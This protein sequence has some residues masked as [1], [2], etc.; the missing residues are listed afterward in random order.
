M[1]VAIAI[2]TFFAGSFWARNANH[3]RDESSRDPGT[4]AS[5]R[6]T[7]G[8]SGFASPERPGR[9]TRSN[10]DPE[11][12]GGTRLPAAFLGTAPD[13]TARRVLSTEALEDREEIDQL[14][15]DAIR[16][17]NPIIRRQAFD[18]ILRSLTPE[19]ALM[20]RESMAENGAGGDQWRLF[21]Y[22]WGAVDA[23]GALAHAPDVPE[24]WRDGFIGSVLTGMASKDP[25][26]AMA[27]IDTLEAGE[28][29]DRMA[30]Q[31]VQGLAD[32]DIGVATDY[33]LG[34]ASQGNERAGRYLED[35]TREVLRSDGL[36]AGRSWAESLP[37]GSLQAGAL[38]RVANRFVDE[39]PQAAAGWATAYAGRD[40]Y[41]RV[42]EEVGDEW[43]E[44]DPAAAV[45][46]LDSLPAG[47]G[48]NEGM[49]SALQEWGRRDPVA[50][51]EY[52]QNM[53]PSAAK[54]AA[55]ISFS[56]TVA[57]EDPQTAIAWAQSVSSQEGRLQ[58][59]T[60][61]GQSWARRDPA[62]AAEW[63]SSAGLPA[64]VQQQILNP[65]RRRR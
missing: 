20:V 30:G 49:S 35:L 31:V 22:A 28:R 13:E 55:V 16:D 34:L 50:A 29:R 4:T 51:G 45:A 15:G 42:V 57:R 23:Q 3:D 53:A 26:A 5:R 41:W 18:R 61:V 25:T 7:A 44:R 56:A 19:N 60:Q 63:A 38:D 17:A 54:D 58:A 64:E 47:R 62:A 32:H 39:D 21:T 1:W 65:P 8:A 40:D 10:R 24:R 59:L 52:L 48:Q 46:W 36:D 12:T 43:A 6:G 9:A 2:A 11:A 27:Y 14:V 33:V 37:S